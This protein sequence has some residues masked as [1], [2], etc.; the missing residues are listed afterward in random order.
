MLTLPV[1]VFVLAGWAPSLASAFTVSTSAGLQRYA[2]QFYPRLH[3]PRHSKIVDTKRMLH[4]DK[5]AV[6]D[7]PS[8]FGSGSD[9]FDNPFNDPRREIFC[10]T[11]ING[12][13][14][15]A[16]GFDMDYTLAQ[17]T[18]TCACLMFRGLLLTKGID[19]LQ[20]NSKFDELAFEGA[21]VKLSKLGYPD[22]ALQFNYE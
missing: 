7:S 9:P 13:S 20:Y 8:F 16:I 1:L 19:V 14:I 12:A 6:L 22:D 2:A 5:N 10:N 21:K 11:E 3:V 17:V 4:A 15:E 18:S